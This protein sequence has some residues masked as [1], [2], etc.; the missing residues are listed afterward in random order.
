M[1]KETFELYN[2]VTIPK[3]GFGTWQVPNGDIAYQAVRDALEVGYIH[4][5]TA[6]VYENEISVG[7]AIQ[8]AHLKR[9][10]IFLISKHMKIQNTILTKHLN[11]YN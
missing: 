8:D 6:Y 11:D 1:L 4:I 5:D 2:G 9:S 10:E 3:V 7:Q